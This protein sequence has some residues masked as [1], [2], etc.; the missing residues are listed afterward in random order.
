MPLP[1]FL[2]IGAQKCGTTALHHLLDQHT[3]IAMSRRKEPNFFTGRWERGVDWYQRQFD[4]RPQRGDASPSYS[5][6]PIWQDTPSRAA[7][8][9]PDARLIYLVRD[10][11]DRIV[12]AWIH[13]TMMGAETRSFGEMVDEENFG[14]SGHLLRTRYATQLERWGQHYPPDRIHVLDSRELSDDPAAALDRLFAF[15]G[16]P[17][18]DV[19][20]GSS[21]YGSSTGRR[22]PPPGIRQLAGF[23]REANFDAAPWRR[24]L[25]HVVTSRIGRPIERPTPTPDQVERIHGLLEDE[26]TRLFEVA[27][28]DLRRNG[29]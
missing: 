15:L 18:E 14:A 27:G 2:V 24:R 21:H 26:L 13:F 19:A 12:S 5:A 4:D 16:V 29:G 23:G 22:A 1:T 6:W 20:S 7:S 11:V 3:G 25:A 9:V 17:S 10:P 8:I 28:V